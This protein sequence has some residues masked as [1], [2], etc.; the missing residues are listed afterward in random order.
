MNLPPIHLEN[1]NLKITVGGLA[2][3]VL[4]IKLGIFYRSF[5]EHSH[6][7]RSYEMHFIPLGQGTLIASGRSYPIIPGTL[8]MTGPDVVHEQI[9]NSSDPMS[10]YCICFELLDYEPTRDPE[11][12]ILT[13]TFA[14]TP[15]W[16]GQDSQNLMEQFEQLSLET[17]RKSIGYHWYVGTIL[18]QIVVKLIRN[19]LGDQM[20]VSVSP[21]PLQTPD[22]KRLATIEHS[23]LSQYSFITVQALA[24]TLGLSV[25]QTER[26]IKQ[27]YGMT[28]TQKRNMARL[29]AAAH[30]LTTTTMTI[31]HIAETVG[32]SSLEQF[33]SAFKINYGMPASRY[34][35]SRSAQIPKTAD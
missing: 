18:E 13:E 8:F 3:N 29:S 32:Y 25:R 35:L 33:C 9:T 30:F 21:T 34:R 17:T 1:T 16:F 22:D 10:E 23:F 5:P 31:S 24:S 4:Y 7:K 14:Q 27:F 2:L 20:A 15:F 12:D 19:Y 26:T 28:F 11:L 6:S